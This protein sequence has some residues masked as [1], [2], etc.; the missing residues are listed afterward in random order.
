MLNSLDRRR[1]W[2]HID[3]GQFAKILASLQ[4][5]NMLSVDF[6][7]YLTIFDDEKGTGWVP[8]LKKVCVRLYTT[9]DHFADHLS[10]LRV[11]HAVEEEVA[12]KD[13]HNSYLV[14]LI[15]ACSV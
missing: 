12:F 1:S 10:P 9:R 3:Q 2:S 7:V 11:S 13:L 6:H 14:D 8:L 5:F 4:A 15:E